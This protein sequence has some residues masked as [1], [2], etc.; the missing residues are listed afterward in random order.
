VV[1]D[2]SRIFWQC[3]LKYDGDYGVKPLYYP[4]SMDANVS[5]NIFKTAVN[6]YKQQRRWAYGVSEIPYFLFG[7]LKNKKIP[8]KRKISLARELIE[9]HLSWALASVLIFCMG[10][11]PLFLGGAE[12]S[13]T[14]LSYNLPRITSW[15]LTLSMVG[16]IV[17]AY[18]SIV[19]LPPRPVG[20]KKFKYVMF[21]FSWIL[22]PIITFF[23]TAIP[24]LDAQTRLMLGEYMGFW[25]TEKVRKKT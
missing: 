15:I 3:F 12:F 19:L 7:F 14:L 1:S 5:S 6:I 13:R 21:A 4:V 8:L 16:L 18:L 9:G 24:A 11:L 17:S 2:D 10:W 25:P 22:V 20:D 23:F